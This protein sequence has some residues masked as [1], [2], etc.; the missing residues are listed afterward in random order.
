[1][2]YNQYEGERE[3]LQSGSDGYKTEQAQYEN[4]SKS[5]AWP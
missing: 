2:R 1:M 4:D 3:Q 5:A